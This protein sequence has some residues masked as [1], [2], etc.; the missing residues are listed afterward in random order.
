MTF[1]LVSGLTKSVINTIEQAAIISVR[2]L[3]AH[4]F[5]TRISNLPKTQQ[6]KG[7]VTVA[8]QKNVEAKLKDIGATLKDLKKAVISFKAPSEIK[9]SNFPTPEKFPKFPTE[10]KVTNFPVPE[11]FPKEIRISNQ[12]DLS[13]VNA[14]IEKL[15]GE[16]K[17][18][19]LNPTINVKA[20]KPERLVVPP[21]SV[22][23]TQ[24]EIDYDKLAELLASQIPNFDYAKLADTLGKKLAE[25]IVTTG[26]G[27]GGGAGFSNSSGRTTKALVDDDR[28][29][30][31]DVLS[32]VEEN[33]STELGYNAAGQLVRIRKTEDGVTKTQLI[34]GDSI[35]DTVVA[36]TK[37][38]SSWS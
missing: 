27:G 13:L 20:P 4:T 33:P 15:T 26:G 8:N 30:Q 1:E 2:S 37:T 6:V 29:L 3:K 12:T 10:I 5:S 32:T 25:M 28:H 14:G 7:T 24:Q 18:L 23:V 36:T 17:K 31:V 34:T 21:A 11:K 9:V 38:Y 35:A 16:V 19:K 22:N